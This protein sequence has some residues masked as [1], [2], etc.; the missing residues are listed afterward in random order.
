MT[1]NNTKRRLF[2]KPS[3]EFV[4]YNISAAEEEELEL[5]INVHNYH[6]V[7]ILTNFKVPGRHIFLSTLERFFFGAD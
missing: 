7:E 2:D 5:Y 3:M 4:H 1:V 6:Q